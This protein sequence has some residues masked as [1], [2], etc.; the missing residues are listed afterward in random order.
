[1]VFEGGAVIGRSTLLSRLPVHLQHIDADV[2][3]LVN[4]RLKGTGV[5]K[6][7]QTDPVGIL[8]SDDDL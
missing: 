1:M 8:E 5:A 7:A 4:M 2:R 3:E 6:A